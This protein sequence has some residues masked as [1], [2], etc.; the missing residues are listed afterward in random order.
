VLGLERERLE[1]LLTAR[2][3]IDHPETVAR[4]AE[5]DAV[6][7]RTDDRFERQG[8]LMPYGQLLPQAFRARNERIDD[9]I[10]ATSSAEPE[11][12]SASGFV[13]ENE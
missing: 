7:Q 1:S 2:L 3:D 10:A 6:K 9:Q 12:L 13:R 8:A 5:V 11:G 4:Q